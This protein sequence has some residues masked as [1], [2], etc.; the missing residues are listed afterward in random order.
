MAIF[1]RVFF[2]HTTTVGQHFPKWDA[3]LSPLATHAT[4]LHTSQTKQCDRCFTLRYGN[5]LHY[6]HP[7]NLY[8]LEKLIVRF[9]T[10]SKELELWTLRFHRMYTFCALCQQQY[11]FENHG[12]EFKRC[13]PLLKVAFDTPES[14]VLDWQVHHHRSILWPPYTLL[15]SVTMRMEL[16]RATGIAGDKKNYI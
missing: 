11:K 13:R 8:T 4:F 3:P 10:L 1:P 16:G 5:I 6:L 12:A 2:S 9:E 15:D 14:H 7:M